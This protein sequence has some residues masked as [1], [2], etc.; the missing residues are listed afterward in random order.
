M[1]AYKLNGGLAAGL[2]LSC[3][4]SS[5]AVAEDQNTDRR[6]TYNFSVAMPDFE[7]QVREGPLFARAQSA[8]RVASVDEG[9]GFE[10]FLSPDADLTLRVR[11]DG[12]L[13]ELPL[14]TEILRAANSSCLGPYSFDE[15]G[16]WAQLSFICR[17]DGEGELSQFLA[18]TNSPEL[19]LTVWFDGE[20]IERIDAFEPLP[21]PMQRAVAMNAYDLMKGSE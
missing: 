3:A 8:I 7:Q 13:R 10:E 17:V 16:D 9:Q 12:S 4:L 20:N 2:L 15:G 19:T 6:P 21:V 18:F 11:R 1:S 14:T 5:V